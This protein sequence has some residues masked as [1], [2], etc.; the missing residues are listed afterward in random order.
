MGWHGRKVIIVVSKSMT[1]IN[2]GGAI[3]MESRDDNKWEMSDD[4]W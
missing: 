2:W 4:S 1:R 3:G